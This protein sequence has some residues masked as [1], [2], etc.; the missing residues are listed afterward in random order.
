MWISAAVLNQIVCNHEKAVREKDALLA[1]F[2]AV[3]S[4]L[5]EARGEKM[6]VDG[7]LNRR[8]ADIEWMRLRINQ[9]EK[10]NAQLMAKV[11][12]IVV[13]TAEIEPIG[14]PRAPRNIDEMLTDP[15]KDPNERDEQPAERVDSVDSILKRHNVRMPVMPLGQEI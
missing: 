10:V 11:T 5:N 4:A 15:F 9:L 7:E 13:E 2:I 3:N 1:Q 6:Q 12:G 8:M 14:R